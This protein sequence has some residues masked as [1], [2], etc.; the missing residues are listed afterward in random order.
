[1]SADNW[2][3]CPRCLDGAQKEAEAK[4]AGVM[5]SY[6]RVSVEEFDA[7]RAQ[8]KDVDPEEYRTFREDYKFYGA[9][10]GEVMAT[11]SGTCTTCDL[12]VELQASRKFW[13]EELDS[14]IF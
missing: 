4:R 13:P 7:A 10:E 5:A 14:S 2:D 1:M 3:V 11:Y 9:S 6:G 8:L 12:H